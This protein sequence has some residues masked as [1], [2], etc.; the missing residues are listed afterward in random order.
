MQGDLVKLDSCTDEDV[1]I[2]VHVFH[3]RHCCWSTDTPGPRHF[4]NS[5]ISTYS[6]S[7]YGLLRLPTAYRTTIMSGNSIPGVRCS[8]EPEVSDD[9]S[10]RDLGPWMTSPPKQNTA[11]MTM[12]EVC[13]CSYADVGS[14]AFVCKAGDNRGC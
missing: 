14:G 4:S 2:D 9:E 13:L 8:A 6:L 1:F 5:N 12:R 10:S 11:P 3:L 7:R